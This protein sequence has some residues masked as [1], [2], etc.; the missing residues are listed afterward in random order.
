MWSCIPADYAS[1]QYLG[2]RDTP[3]HPNGTPSPQVET[4]PLKNKKQKQT[5][6]QKKTYMSLGTFIMKVA[7]DGDWMVSSGRAFQSQMVCGK[8]EWSR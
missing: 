4:P 8:K 1:P 2:A 7:R 6:K 3:E 5:N